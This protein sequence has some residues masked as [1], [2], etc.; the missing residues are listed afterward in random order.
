MTDEHDK[1][2]EMI[3]ECTLLIIKLNPDPVT[4]NDFIINITK[5]IMKHIAFKYLT[6]E[7]LEKDGYHLDTAKLLEEFSLAIKAAEKN[8]V[9]KADFRATGI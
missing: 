3:A 7:A 1:L 6:F 5:I 2:D 8:H 9:S 4:L